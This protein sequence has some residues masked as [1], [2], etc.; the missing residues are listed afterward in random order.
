MIG[1][2]GYGSYSTVWLARDSMKSRYV[3]LKVIT[4]ASSGSNPEAK[5]SHHLREGNLNHPGRDVVSDLLDDFWFDGPNGRH[6]CLV[7]EVLGSSIVEAKEESTH[8][9]F[10]LKTARNITAQLALGLSYIHSC[11]V[12]H[13]G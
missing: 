9:L 10:P 2:L 5:I 3:S 11:G 1:K 6:L 13:R 8:S 7:G 12:L 4:A